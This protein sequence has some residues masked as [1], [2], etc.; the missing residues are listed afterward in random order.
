MYGSNHRAGWREQAGELAGIRIYSRSVT[1]AI[2]G[3]NFAAAVE[4]DVSIAGWRS[5]LC[6]TRKYMER[7]RTAD[8][9]WHHPIGEQ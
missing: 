1:V 7:E 9:L 5:A 8:V 2:A 3:C 6:I 4:A